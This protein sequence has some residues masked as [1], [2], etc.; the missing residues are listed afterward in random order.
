MRIRLGAWGAR[1]LRSHEPDDARE[2]EPV[3][4]PPEP[5]PDPHP[6]PAPPPSEPPEPIAERQPEP[7]LVALPPLEPEP[8]AGQ[9]PEP[10][11]FPLVLRDQTP[12]AWNLWEL[13]RIATETVHKDPGH[14]E[15]RA[16]LL[17]HMRQFA[18]AAGDLPLE[19]DPLVREAFGA[20][21]AGIA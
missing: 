6:E 3:P 1:L 18:T 11:V 21:L 13:E 7:V 4:E 12:H 10:E 16:L 5:P 2:P 9:E 14:S 15:E 20:D 19:F 17:L 8:E